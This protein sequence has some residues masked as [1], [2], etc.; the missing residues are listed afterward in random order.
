M[1]YGFTKDHG[2]AVVDTTRKVAS[3]AYPTSIHHS[4]ARRDPAGTAARMLAEA[5]VPADPKL[6]RQY[7]VRIAAQLLDTF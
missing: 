7:Y 6:A 3:Y 4:A 1:V 5:Y 2:F